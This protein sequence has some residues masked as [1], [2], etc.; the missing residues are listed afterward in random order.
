MMKCN[1]RSKEKKQPE[2]EKVPYPDCL[3]SERMRELSK[4][5][6]R[7]KVEKFDGFDRRTAWKPPGRFTFFRVKKS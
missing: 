1:D 5:R 3:L 2:P 4:P 6:D 7:Y